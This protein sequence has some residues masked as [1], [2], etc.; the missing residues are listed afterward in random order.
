MKKEIGLIIA[1]VA[2]FLIAIV[3]DNHISQLLYLF[4]NNTLQYYF[5]I[6][7]SYFNQIV[8]II[9]VILFIL[10]NWP[11]RILKKCKWVRKNKKVFLLSMIT[12]ITSSATVKIL[13]ETIKRKRPYIVLNLPTIEKALGYS[14][15]SGHTAI[16]FSLLFP[17][18]ELKIKNKKLNRIIKGLLISYAILMA[19]SRIYLLSHYASDVIASIM[20]SFVWYKI[21]KKIVEKFKYKVNF[22]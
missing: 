8:G 10:S 18:L 2:L 20:I 5:C 11:S 17:L 14:F 3:N 6:Y 9:A 4:E 19:L 22:I 21:N 13:K 15:P 16:A 1:S 7:T 12:L